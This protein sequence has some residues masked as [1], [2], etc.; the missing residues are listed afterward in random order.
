MSLPILG[1]HYG[2]G[3]EKMFA[4]KLTCSGTEASLFN[5]T[6]QT[7]LNATN[8]QCSTEKTAGVRCDGTYIQAMI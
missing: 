4:S 2:S 6:G 7:I 5:C 3:N 1:G 8:L